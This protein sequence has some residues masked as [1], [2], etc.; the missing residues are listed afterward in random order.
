MI[1]IFKKYKHSSYT[2]YLDGNNKIK[3]KLNDFFAGY[4]FKAFGNTNKSFNDVVYKDLT[5]LQYTRFRDLSTINDRSSFSTNLLG[6]STAFYRIL[7]QNYNGGKRIKSMHSPIPIMVYF[8]ERNLLYI[9]FD[10]F[11]CMGEI[12][13][14]TLLNDTYD[15]LLKE[16]KVCLKDIKF[17]KV[18]TTKFIEKRSLNVMKEFINNQIQ[19][20]RTF[21]RNTEGDIASYQ[22]ELI[23]LAIKRVSLKATIEA[24]DDIS[25]NFDKRIKKSL[26]EV[27]ALPFVK[28]FDFVPTGIKFS[29]GKISIDSED[30]VVDKNGDKKQVKIKCYLGDYIV[31]VGKKMGIFNKDYLQIGS[32]N[33]HHMHSSNE[34]TC[35]GDYTEKIHELIAT[36]QYK[37][38][39][40]LLYAYLKSYNTDDCILKL[41]RFYD[42]RKAEGKYDWKGNILKS[43]KDKKKLERDNVIKIG[44]KV[45][46]SPSSEYYDSQSGDIGVSIITEMEKNEHTNPDTWK[47]H[48][49]NGYSNY[50]RLKDLEVVK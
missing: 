44:V 33:Y 18:N 22:G 35:W 47:F 19:E 45:R 34:L 49:D 20:S 13:D 21:L 29:L 50:Y 2:H 7:Y 38:L 40:M 24:Y 12:Y 16:F 48:F 31:E 6:G 30:T 37:Q 10:I 8:E 14:N 5:I 32:R 3:K 41:H 39:C 9:T 11:R 28:S 27:K 36:F 17:K 42:A 46:M 43:Y 1:D 4:G 23:K 26:I 15:K 25:E